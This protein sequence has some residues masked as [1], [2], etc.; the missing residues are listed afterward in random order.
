MASIFCL[1]K[2]LCFVL[3]FSLLGIGSVAGAQSSTLRITLDVPATCE[4]EPENQFSVETVTIGWKVSGGAAPFEVLIEGEIHEGASG[5]VEVVC[6][7]WTESGSGSGPISI[8]ATVIDSHG[9]RA[10]AVADMYAIRAISQSLTSTF[11]F[12]PG[13]TYKIHQLLLTMP[14]EGRLS[15]GVY[16]SGDCPVWGHACDDRFELI[17]NEPSEV[18]PSSLWIR[19]WTGTEY[20]RILDG[21]EFAAGDS[22]TEEL[23]WPQPL[24]ASLFDAVLDSR[25]V[26]P[27]TVQAQQVSDLE[28]RNLSIQLY[29]PTYCNIQ[30]YS[31]ANAIDVSWEVSGGRAPYEVTIAGRR[32]LGRVGRVPVN[33]GIGRIGQPQAGHLRIQGTA[34]DG[35]GRIASGR[36][37]VYVLGGFWKSDETLPRQRPYLHGATVVTFPLDLKEPLAWATPARETYEYC[38]PED[39]NRNRCE[40][41]SRY[42]LT[43]GTSVA[44]FGF[45]H[46]T[47]IVNERTQRDHAS[48]ALNEMIDRI[49][50][51]FN[52]PPPLPDGF[53]ESNA[54]LSVTA[55][56]EPAVCE[57][58]GTFGQA[59]LHLTATGGRWWPLQVEVDGP[60]VGSTWPHRSIDCGVYAG[61]EEIVVVARDF[62]AEPEEASLRLPLV[63][64]RTDFEAMEYQDASRLV[65]AL[66][67]EQGFCQTGET[68][69]LGEARDELGFDVGAL[70][71]H[72]GTET[73]SG[74]DNLACADLPGRMRITALIPSDYG[75]E[76]MV[77]HSYVL[78]VRQAQPERR[79]QR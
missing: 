30:G 12:Q 31:R 45:G 68:F 42:R 10:S 27:R 60:T 76:R 41:A 17:V 47:G 11:A 78:P 4:A 63:T 22:E 43:D 24:A 7:Y 32:Y 77:E 36:A 34:V 37:D 21:E 70:E 8:Q 3:V 55:L 9:S 73:W 25:R 16:V 59:D 38:P 69:T 35:K 58:Y 56:L 28:S 57:Y 48:P 74:T 20:R 1:P 79:A 18:R 71:A 50:D 33:C 14:F 2:G 13:E 44:S 52:R 19:R 15:M 23:T 6:G 49:I 75:P 5:S 64:H 26:P 61:S 54:P 40:P 62:G 46:S 53:V 65:R 72:D 29:A 51:S 67:P 66:L 39:Q